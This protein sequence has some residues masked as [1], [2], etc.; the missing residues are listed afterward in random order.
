MVI[1]FLYV[2]VYRDPNG[3]SIPGTSSQQNIRNPETDAPFWD[4]YDTINQLYLELGKL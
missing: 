2:Y 4:T 1:L 3:D